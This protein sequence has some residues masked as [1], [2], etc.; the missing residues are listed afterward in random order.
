[1]RPHG[2]IAVW[3]AGLGKED[4][5]KRSQETQLDP[6]PKAPW[7]VSLGSKSRKHLCGIQS[8]R[9]QK[10]ILHRDCHRRKK[11]DHSFKGLASVHG[12]QGP[13]TSH[14]LPLQQPRDLVS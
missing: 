12:R 14:Q 1:M 6:P 5:S 10:S 2:V 13:L 11:A 8:A 9:H 4:G 3:W 7:S